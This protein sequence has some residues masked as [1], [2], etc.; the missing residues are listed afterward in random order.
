M[1]GVVDEAGKGIAPDIFHLQCAKDGGSTSDCDMPDA[2]SQL[3]RL[4][5]A[6]VV[7]TTLNDGGGTQMQ[8]QFD[9]VIVGECVIF[10]FKYKML[11]SRIICTQQA[12]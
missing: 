3:S 7:C 1:H 5:R 12:I 6:S 2:S 11:G 8:I 10:V 4:Q 9:V